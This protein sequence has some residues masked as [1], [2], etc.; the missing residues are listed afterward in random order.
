MLVRRRIWRTLLIGY[1]LGILFSALRLSR[2]RT[3]Q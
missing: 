3:A 1:S 2:K